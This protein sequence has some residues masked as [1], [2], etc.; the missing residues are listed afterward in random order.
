MT[1]EKSLNYIT[2][3]FSELTMHKEILI[4]IVLGSLLGLVVAFGVWKTNSAFESRQKVTEE[5]GTQ[6]EEDA[7]TSDVTELKL[8]LIGPSD[9]TAVT[10]STLVLSGAMRPSSLVLAVGE[11]EQI[12]GKSNANGEFELELE[13]VGGLNQISIYAFDNNGGSVSDSVMIAYSS[14]LKPRGEETD[15]LEEKVEAKIEEAREKLTF[16]MGTLTDISENAFQLRSESGEISQVSLDENTTFA[17]IIKTSKEIES[18]ELAI[19]DFVI[20]IGASTTE[21]NGLLNGKRILVS[22]PVE[23]KE[24]VVISGMIN[25]VKSGEFTVN[26]DGKEETFATDSATK[27]TYFDKDGDLTSGKVSNIEEDDQVVVVAEKDG[28]ELTALRVHFL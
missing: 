21:N 17:N 7:T 2:L 20:A 8:T 24:W 11:D 3:F 25:S 15:D 18:S 12:I 23:T 22:S 6:E 28:D 1:S 27:V 19:G 5:G 9:K 26:A 4:A 16:Y 10:N 14:Q 13:L